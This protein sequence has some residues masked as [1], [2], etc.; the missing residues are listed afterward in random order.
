MLISQSIILSYIQDGKP[1]SLEEISASKWF[2]HQAKEAM[3]NLSTVFTYCNREVLRM[4]DV[5]NIIRRQS[6]ATPQWMS[7][8][9]LGLILF[10]LFKLWHALF[11]LFQFLKSGWIFG[12]VLIFSIGLSNI[13]VL[14]GLGSLNLNNFTNIHPVILYH[15][16]R[17]L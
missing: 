4:V 17:I 10:P 13:F 5:E 6:A 1:L 8:F 7:R 16:H 11:S 2:P 14:I 9:G 3:N 15:Y 12:T